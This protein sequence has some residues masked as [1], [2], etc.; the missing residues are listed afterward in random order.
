M[1]TALLLLLLVV[2][3]LFGAR[4]LR[5]RYAGVPITTPEGRHYE[6]R[7]LPDNCSQPRICAAQVIFVTTSTDTLQQ[8]AEARGLLSWVGTA[9]T[10]GTFKGAILYAVVPGWGKLLPPKSS[11]S[12]TFGWMGDRWQY[13]GSEAV[14]LRPA[15][16]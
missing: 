11:R 7:K 13:V 5:S 8:Q 9:G 10:G 4:I 15:R 1:R 14:D 16:D 2:T 6:V 3:G 12:Y